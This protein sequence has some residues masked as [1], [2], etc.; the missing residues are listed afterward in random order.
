M[1]ATLK[2]SI[3]SVTLF[4]FLTGLT[5]TILFFATGQLQD[6]LWADEQTFLATSESFSNR[7]IPS[8]EQL[9]SYQELNTPLPFIIYGQVIYFFKGAP[10]TARL[11]NLLLSIVIAALIGWPKSRKRFE[12]IL[13]LMGLFLFPYFLWFSTRFYTD[14]FAVFF[15]LLGVFF[16]RQKNHVASG[17]MFLLGIASRQ[18]ILAFPLATA[19][20]ELL[21][22]IREKRRP[23]LSFFLPSIAALSI[24]G[25]V[26]FF[27]GLAPQTALSVRNVPAVQQ[28]LW[29]LTPE[30]GLY[31]LA[32]IGFFY[33]IPESLLFRQHFAEQPLWSKKNLLIAAG[34]MTAFI[35]SPNLVFAKGVVWKISSFLPIGWL[36]LAF[37]Y[38]MALL[39]CL[40][41]SR[42]S[43]PFLIL[44]FNL[45]IMMKAFP[46][47]K[48]A[49][50]IIV[51]FWYLKSKDE[52]S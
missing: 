31:F 50:P 32:V 40:R 8:L 34:L 45:L 12:S 15:T 6:P 20:H 5:Y 38:V 9:R 41:F 23:S 30:S 16:Y 39:P 13:S 36:K 25:W 22:A 26:L 1:N 28:S 21:I 17:V 35:L 10:F 46:W 43:F 3:S 29:A 49:L 11:L 48:Y 2:F 7:L 37:L 51:I 33:V 18:F 47:D 44:F 42:I 24:V 14:I 27:G 19:A 52:M 4:F